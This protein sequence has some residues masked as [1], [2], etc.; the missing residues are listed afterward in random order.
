M[1]GGVRAPAAT[2]FLEDNNTTTEPQ[3]IL[4]APGEAGRRSR[5]VIASTGRPAMLAALSAFSRL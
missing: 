4:V 3:V 5:S 1:S 2:V